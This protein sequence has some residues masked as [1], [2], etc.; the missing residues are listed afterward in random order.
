MT[1]NGKKTLYGITLD[2]YFTP[3]FCSST[4]TYFGGLDE[5]QAFIESLE[6][7]EQ[8]LITKEAFKGFDKSLNLIQAA[9]VGLCARAEA[10]REVIVKSYAI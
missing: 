3:S 10:W 9:E 4:K 6:D 5:I 7:T 8:Y 2:D 1:S